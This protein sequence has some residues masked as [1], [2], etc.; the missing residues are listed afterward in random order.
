VADVRKIL[1]MIEGEHIHLSAWTDVGLMGVVSAN[2]NFVII[3]NLATRFSSDLK[4]D[5]S[6]SVDSTA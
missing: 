4:D 2:H 1:L 6:H 3:D 5:Q